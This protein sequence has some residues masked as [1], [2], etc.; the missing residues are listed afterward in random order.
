MP[1]QITR[2]C[3]KDIKDSSNLF[4]LG[5]QDE[6]SSSRAILV[7][8]SSALKLLSERQQKRTVSDIVKNNYALYLSDNQSFRHIQI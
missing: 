2:G 8:W 1:A 3:E 4:Y 5:N 7:R 6:L